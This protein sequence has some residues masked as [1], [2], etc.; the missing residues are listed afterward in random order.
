MSHSAANSSRPAMRTFG[1]RLHTVSDPRSAKYRW[2]LT[3]ANGRVIAMSGGTF[4]EPASAVSAF[5]ATCEVVD[6]LTV[7][8]TH[9]AGRLGW[10][11]LA[12]DETGQVVASSART[13]ERRATCQR[14]YEQFLRA[15]S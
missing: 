7:V 10:T 5:E 12:S 11:W 14:S 8:V 9:P 6:R 4:D 3:A 13:Y 15:V 1:I 2:Q